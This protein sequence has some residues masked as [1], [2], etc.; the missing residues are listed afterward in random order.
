METKLDAR[1]ALAVDFQSILN[2]ILQLPK[3]YKE[4]IQKA[5]QEES[6][7]QPD[8]KTVGYLKGT[9]NISQ[10]QINTSKNWE[11]VEGTL[12]VEEPV[13]ELLQT[14]KKMG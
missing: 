11:G 4:I 1:F 10:Y 12:M 13:E 2:V 7:I 5:L 6:M 9:L 8:E 3:E 14:L